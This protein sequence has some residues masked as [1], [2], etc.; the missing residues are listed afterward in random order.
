[1]VEIGRRVGPR[2]ELGHQREGEHVRQVRDRREDRV[3]AV[4]GERAHARAARLPHGR[5]S[6]DARA[7]RSRGS[8]ARITLRSSNSEGKAA[9]APLCSVPAMGCPGTNDASFGAECAARRRDHVLLGAAG[10]GDARAVGPRSAPRSLASSAGIARRVSATSTT[11]ASAASCAHAASSVSARSMT[12]RSS[13]RVEIRARA[14]D[15][16]D[17]ADRAG[18][19]QRQRAGAA[20]EPDADDD[21]LLQLASS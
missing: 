6:R 18:A 7:M 15:A 10:V 16:D 8:G 21:E 11:S 4:G 1:M 3:V 20:D 12:P 14:A 19:L 2:G 17:L 5:D 13:G 9:A